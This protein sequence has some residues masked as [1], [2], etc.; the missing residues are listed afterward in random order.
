M[1]LTAISSENFGGLFGGQKLPQCD[2]T[3]KKK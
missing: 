1:E 2:T 3:T